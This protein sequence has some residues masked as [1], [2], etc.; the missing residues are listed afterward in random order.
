MATPRPTRRAPRRLIAPTRMPSSVT[1]VECNSRPQASARFST[2][3]QLGLSTSLLQWRPVRSGRHRSIAQPRAQTKARARS[4][5]ARKAATKPR[6]PR[7]AADFAPAGRPSDAPG[8][9][10]AARTSSGRERRRRRDMFT[11][12]VFHL[13]ARSDSGASY[14][15]QLIEQIEEITAGAGVAQPEHDVSAPAGAG[16]RRPDR[17]PLGAS[18]EAQPPPLHDHGQRARGVRAPQ[19]GIEPFLDSIVKT[20]S[21]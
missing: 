17:R 7:V 21:R 1:D 6:A 14:G 10:P 4:R 19:G 13:I 11:L 5:A 2:T 16:G 8:G 15:N 18:R 12:L 3:R 9:G 20:A